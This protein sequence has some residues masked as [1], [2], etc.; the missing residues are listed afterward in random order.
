[1][2][3]RAAGARR[4]LIPAVLAAVA[5]AL[6]AGAS[7][8]IPP[9][10]A[11]SCAQRDAADADTAS[12]ELPFFLCDDGTPEAGGRDPNLTGDK[13]V[14]VPAAYDGF[15]GLPPRSAAAAATPGANPDGDVALD[16]DLSFPDPD[17]FAPPPGGY[18]LVVFMHG[19]CAGSKA[20]WEAQTVDEPSS[21]EKWHYSNAWFAA[22][23][24]AVM[25]YTSRGF[26]AGKGPTDP[27]GDG[28]TGETQIDHRS[29]EIN[30]YQSL[31]A[32]IADTSFTVDGRGMT[33]DPARIVT[34]GGS[35]GG[36]FA[37]MALT[38][39][40]WTSPGGKQLRLA[41]TTP[42][43]GWTDLAY[44][45]VPNGRH[46]EG[47]AQPVDGSGTVSPVGFPKR[48]VVT[49]LYATGQQGAT[50]PPAVTDAFLCL[51]SP[52]P[53]ASNPQCATVVSDVLPSF[54]A[55]RSA[56]YQNDFF[57]KLASGE[58]PPVPVFSAG[59]LTDPLFPGREHRRM[60][61]RLKAIRAD[62]PVQEYYGDYQHFVQNKRKEWA[63]LCGQRVCGL[64]DQPGGDLN[65]D[66]A[67]VTRT[68]VTTRLNRFLDHYVKPQGNPSQAAPARDVTTALQICPSNASDAFPADGPGETFT[69][70]TFRGL[71]PNQLTIVRRG[72]QRTTSTAVPN[73]H[74]LNAD[75]LLQTTARGG[76]CPE[77]EEPAGP[78]VA[79]YDSPPLERSY[80]MIG[81]TRVRVPFE[82]SAAELQL[83][84]RLYDVAPDGSQTMVDRGF[85]TL[86]NA[87][88]GAVR[89]PAVFDLLGNAWRF[90]RGHTIRVELAQDDDPY[91]KRATTPSSLTLAGVTLE[92]PVRESSARVG[93]SGS[94]GGGGGGGSGGGGGDDDGDSSRGGSGGGAGGRGGGG[95]GA[96]A[97][98]AGS[99][100]GGLPF[101][102]L[103][104]AG[105][106]LSGA[107]LA[108]A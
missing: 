16:V 93:D 53:V 5:A 86:A 10:L 30:D 88:G 107:G 3:L 1:M 61:E 52:L 77:N 103:A 80:A 84:A 96:A 23:G 49:G 35:Y 39:P 36:G 98:T 6:P 100:G 58:I 29:F 102:G 79:V 28:S 62:Y 101:T 27:D 75:P 4:L 37:W 22:R 59:T 57:A 46:L 26:V 14:T 94:N 99:G 66:P 63:D 56:Y 18:P 50:F 8:A 85:L 32:Q 106:A 42:R 17:R 69:A 21:A 60:V 51:Q 104:L 108:V 43:Y 97:G 73:P 74:A 68:G 47:H 78:G 25:T 90:P 65:A 9:T 11:A 91:I 15:A 7:A 44:S 64:S 81:A 87:G 92:V 31:V 33:I 82:G 38:D 54:V 76:R 20:S 89:S 24:Y 83:N 71:A 40:V 13:A 72:D 95:G 67:G 70:S 105:L 45:L 41:A 19:C 2:I 12:L 34:S 55:D 48:T